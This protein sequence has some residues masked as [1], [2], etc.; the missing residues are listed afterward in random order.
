MTSARTAPLTAPVAIRIVFCVWMRHKCIQVEQGVQVAEPAVMRTMI[1]TP[2]T[3]AGALRGLG[4]KCAFGQQVRT[5][6]E[7][8]AGTGIDDFRVA[9]VTICYAPCGPVDEKQRR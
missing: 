9:L 6:Q 7:D 4:E 2:R 5:E 8:H 3:G 1:E